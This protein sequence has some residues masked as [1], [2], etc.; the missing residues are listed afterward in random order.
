METAQ[1]LFRQY[2]TWLRI[3]AS[4]RSGR[5]EKVPWVSLMSA[6]GSVVALRSCSG[7]CC[8]WHEVDGVGAR[9]VEGD[10]APGIQGRLQRCAMPCRLS[11]DRRTLVPDVPA[12]VPCEHHCL[13]RHPIGLGTRLDSNGV[14]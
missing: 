10:L 14:T 9:V 6:P 7:R 1:P 5:K 13:E 3:C 2:S 8:G 4:V 12:L 11:E